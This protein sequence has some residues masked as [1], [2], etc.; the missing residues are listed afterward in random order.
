MIVDDEFTRIVAQL[1]ASMYFGCD[2]IGWMD[3][4]TASIQNLMHYFM[5]EKRIAT[6]N[7]PHLLQNNLNRFDEALRDQ[8]HKTGKMFHDP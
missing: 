3:L 7:L 2:C 8:N 5:L 4:L 1:I 6:H